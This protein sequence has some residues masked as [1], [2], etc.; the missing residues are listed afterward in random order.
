M[1]ENI[2]YE[3]LSQLKAGGYE[4]LSF[5]KIAETLDISRANVHHHFK[6]K[7]GLAMAATTFYIE[8]NDAWLEDI[9]KRHPNNFLACIDEIEAQILTKIQNKPNECCCICGQL[10]RGDDIPDE[11]KQLAK[12]HFKTIQDLFEHIIQNSQQSQRI[13]TDLSP[14]QLATQTIALLMGLSQLSSTS[15]DI[16]HYVSSI[17][18]ILRQ[19]VSN[20]AVTAS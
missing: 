5:A 2:L 17:S 7:L 15:D 20:H 14:P 4:S 3:S 9:A 1:R 19:S 18:G 12:S 6:D 11:L 8:Q 16:D 10:L 13:R